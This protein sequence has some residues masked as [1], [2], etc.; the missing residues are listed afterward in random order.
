[1]CTN[2]AYEIGLW[3]EK[4][5]AI[6]CLYGSISSKFGKLLVFFSASAPTEIDLGCSVENCSELSD[7]DV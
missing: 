5:R 2:L 3:F 4:I 1:M 6:A 7:N